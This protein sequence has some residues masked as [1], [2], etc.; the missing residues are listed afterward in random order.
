MFK[1]SLFN[2]RINPWL[3]LK[4]IVLSKGLI[5]QMGIQAPNQEPRCQPCREHRYL[6]NPSVRKPHKKHPSLL[7]SK[8]HFTYRDN[9]KKQFWQ[10][11]LQALTVPSRIKSLSSSLISLPP[12][13]TP[14]CAHDFII[15][16]SRLS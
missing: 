12:K 1:I 14:Q 7:S 15:R 6:H 4:R 8:T 16:P 13:K 11:Q 5:S 2:L 3:K 10:N 9:S